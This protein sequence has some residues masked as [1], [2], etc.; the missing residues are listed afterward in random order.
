MIGAQDA[1]AAVEV[2]LEEGDGLVESA[3]ILV[4]AGK[5]AAR[6]EGVGLVGTQNAGEVLEVLLV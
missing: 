1:G 3:G 6:G 5:A 2:L 4:G